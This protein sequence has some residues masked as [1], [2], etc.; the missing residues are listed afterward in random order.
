[1]VEFVASNNIYDGSTYDEVALMF[2][3]FKQMMEKKVKSQHSSKKKDSKFK[4]KCKEERYEITYFECRKLGRMKVECPKLYKKKEY[5]LGTKKSWMVTW[6]DS[7]N[8]KSNNS[9][10]EQANICLITDIDKKC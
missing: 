10:E 2:N 6:D 4:K 7:D 9:D 8:K 3:K 5:T 1:M